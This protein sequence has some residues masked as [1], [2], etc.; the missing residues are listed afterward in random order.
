MTQARRELGIAGED[1]AA[2]WYE[3][4]GYEVVDRNWRCRDGELDLVLR[5]GGQLVVCEVKAR[6]SDRFGTPAEAVTPA[7]QRKLRML[8]GRYLSEAAP[9]RP[10]GVRF[11]V[12]C[13]LR[14]QLTVIEGAF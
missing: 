7:K 5:A 1:L 13:V 14:G 10:S 2:R 4:R 11:D 8:A 9:F 3:E 6:S 12:A